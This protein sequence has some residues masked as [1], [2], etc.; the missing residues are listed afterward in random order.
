MNQRTP[1]GATAFALMIL[2]CATWG[3]QQVTIKIAGQGVSPLLQS[4]LRSAIALLLLILWARWQGLALSQADGTLRAGLLAGSLF[5]LE[6]AFIYLGLS[7]TTASRMIVALYTAPCFT[8]LGLHCFVPGEEMRRRHLLGVVLA[9]A[10]I[11]LGFADA[12][13]SRPDAWI[14]DFLGL[15]AAL[16]WATTTVLIRAS[17]L[18]RISATKVLFYQLAVSAACLLPLSLLIG[19]TGITH[20]SAPVLLALA[21]QGVIVAFASY[22]VWFWLLTRYITTR[23]SVFSFLTPLFGVSFGV[24]LLGDRLTTSFAAAAACVSAGIV[25]VNLPALRQAARKKDSA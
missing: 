21:Y 17:G 14:G 13:G 5:A 15:L 4:G 10:G 12:S 20:L 6:F 24:L 23:L 18:A 2:L 8:V 22:L 9:F 16:G 3:F 11:V 19:E 7:Y 25:L 1:P